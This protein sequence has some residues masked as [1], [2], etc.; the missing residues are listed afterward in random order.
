M[1]SWR[2]TVSDELEKAA[3]QAFCL[4]TESLAFM[5]PEPAAPE[6]VPCPAE[7]GMEARVTFSGEVTGEMS[8]ALC[9][10]TCAEVARNLMGLDFDQEVPPDQAR[11]AL[12]E[13]VNVTCGETLVRVTPGDA[14]FDLSVPRLQRFETSGWKERLSSDALFFVM[15]GDPAILHIEPEEG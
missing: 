14:V 4:V 12:Q 7:P 2:T 9:R 6:D 15:E 3:A 11:D 13:L 10:G 5:F 1:K 8:L